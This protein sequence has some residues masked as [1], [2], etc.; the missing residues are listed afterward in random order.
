MMV[1]V[2]IPTWSSEATELCLGGTTIYKH[3]P[4]DGDFSRHASTKSRF[5]VELWSCEN[6][7]LAAPYSTKAS[8][9]ATL[10]WIPR[11]EK[12]RI[13]IAI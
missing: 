2:S 5:V 13:A 7:R 12:L 1:P 11:V 6:R 8:A 4:A 10:C 3:K 9:D